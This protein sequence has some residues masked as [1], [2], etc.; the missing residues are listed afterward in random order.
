MKNKLSI[1]FGAIILTVCAVTTALAQDVKITQRMSANGQVVSE[2]TTYI[3][4][5]RKR[6]ENKIGAQAGMDERVAA[7]MPTIA[8]IDQCDRKRKLQ[9]ND[10]ARKYY[11][12][13]LDD[14][15]A[16]STSGGASNM[17]SSPADT[18]SGGFVTY[19]MNITDARVT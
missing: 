19:T 15:G 2:N 9:I 18:R 17:S 6:T 4:G 16:A 7:M 13:P 1:F 11:I 12:T 10:K 8:N 5:T 3:K 14:A